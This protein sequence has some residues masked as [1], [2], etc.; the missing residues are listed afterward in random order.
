MHNG[1]FVGVLMHQIGA[2][3]KCSRTCPPGLT[4]A[5]FQ[6]LFFINNLQRERCDKNLR[7]IPEK[8][9]VTRRQNQPPPRRVWIDFL[10]VT[11]E[12]IN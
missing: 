8:V 11:N 12:I 7:G 6:K 3:S 9:G 2:N 4:P 5:H 10:D 1:H